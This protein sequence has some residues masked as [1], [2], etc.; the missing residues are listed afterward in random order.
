SGDLGFLEDGNLYVVGRI[1]DLIV[2]DGVNVSPE[3]VEAAA[4][5]VEPKLLAVGAFAVDANGSEGIGLALE[6]SGVEKDG[7]ANFCARLRS[8]I[9]AQ[10]EFSIQRV[11]LVRPGLLPRTTS[12][13]IQRHGISEGFSQGRL[14]VLFD[15]G[16]SEGKAVVPESVP[17]LEAVMDAVR[18]VTGHAD[19]RPSD[20]LSKLDISSIDVTRIIALLRKSTGVALAHPDLF[21]AVDFRSLA[22]KI[23]QANQAEAFDEI[24]P[25]SGRESGLI[26][27]SQERMAFLHRLEPDS[28]AYHV[29]GAVELSGPLDVAALEKAYQEVLNSHPILRTRCEEKD[30]QPTMSFDGPTSPIERRSGDV[31]AEFAEFGRRPFD[32]ANDSPIR[33]CLVA[34]GPDRHVL[35]LCAHHVVADGWSARVLIRQLAINY[36]IYRS[37]GIPEA[38]SKGPDFIDY[39]AWQRKRIDE[40]AADEQVAYWKD[41]LEG[42]D[43]KLELVTDFSRPPTVSSEGSAV[44]ADLPTELDAAI[45]ELARKCRATP[46]MVRFAAWLLLLRAHGGGDDLVSAVPVANRHHAVSGDLIGTLVNTLPLRLTLDGHERFTDLIGRVRDAAF[47]MQANQEAPFE[48]IIEAVKPERAR[49]RAPIAQ[50]M[51]DHQELPM[52]AVWDGGVECSPRLI[53]RGAVQFDLSLVSFRLPDRT[54]LV[55]EYRSDLFREETVNAMLGRYLGILKQA[56][57]DPEL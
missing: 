43:G 34:D 28:A 11:L 37:G 18:T 38:E 8:E 50:V 32:L 16:E 30:G 15:D 25:G 14:A 53:H 42:H 20:D 6:V 4:M 40:G 55:F 45:A 57:A 10:G 39:A 52:P 24:V 17:A 29:F 7:Q 3:D 49:D 9:A 54:Q 22:D 5:A 19:I 12:G 41:R 35:G 21:D 26:S 23:G 51:F 36:G 13:K 46:F 56:C 48:K 44:L 27:H 47:G 31:E 1:K 2:V 33:L